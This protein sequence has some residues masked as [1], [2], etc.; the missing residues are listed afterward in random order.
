MRKIIFIFSL[1]VSFSMEFH[2]QTPFSCHVTLDSVFHGNAYLTTVR[3]SMVRVQTVRVDG[4]EFD[5]QYPIA[6]ADEYRVSVRPYRFGVSILAEPGCH[7]DIAVKGSDV[8]VSSDHGKEQLLW[9]ELD[10]E[11]SPVQIKAERLAQ[12]YM[13][14]KA[15]GDTDRAK[16]ALNIYQAYYDT[17]NTMKRAFVKKYPLTLAGV[18]AAADYLSLEY[19]DMRSLYDLIKDTPFYY[20]YY[21]RTFYKRYKEL[22]D[23]WI[24]D[25]PAPDFTTYDADGKM[26]RLSDFRGKYVLLD[27]WASWCVPCR[28]KMKELKL[29]YPQLKAKGVEVVSISMDE[30]RD[31]WLKASRQDGIAWVN[32]CDV[33]PFGENVIGK[34]YKVSAVPTLFVISPEGI[35]VSQNPTKEYLLK[36]NVK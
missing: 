28:A 27:F 23:K 21:W 11:L 17:I 14:L 22:A 34:A 29:I 8:T 5:L 6:R 26:V 15:Q 20:T 24:Q 33:K 35:I 32:T 31:A 19:P 7:Y 30:K 9:N 13:D 1:L 18:R 3:D 4:K 25:K 12:N 36:L 2:A 16:A 10:K